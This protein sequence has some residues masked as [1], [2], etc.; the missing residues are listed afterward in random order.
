MNPVW[1]EQ[2]DL[3][4]YTDQSKVLE[5]FV[6]DFHSRDDYEGKCTINLNE[7]AKEETHKIWK[8]LGEG[9]G[10][11]LLL[12]TISGTLG[13]DAISDLNTYIPDPKQE[14]SIARK[15]VI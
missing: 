9:T 12:V 13:S 1:S 15:Y 7:L 10:E 8:D 11:I 14:K 3:H 2:F 4:T 6:C 5:I